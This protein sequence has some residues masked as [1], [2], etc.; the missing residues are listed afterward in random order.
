MR[1]FCA[2]GKVPD[3]GEV[4]D[5]L[6]EIPLAMLILSIDFEREDTVFDFIISVAFLED[7]IFFSTGASCDGW[8]SGSASELDH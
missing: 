3:F 1:E 5:G 7:K 8:I 4:C 2:R 6:D